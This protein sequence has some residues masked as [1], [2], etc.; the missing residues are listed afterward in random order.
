MK[1]KNFI[2]S[3]IIILILIISVVVYYFL[4]LPKQQPTER[5]QGQSIEQPINGK[6]NGSSCIDRYNNYYK[7]FDLTNHEEFS[8]N[9]Q[10]GE[11]DVGFKKDMSEQEIQNFTKSKGLKLKSFIDEINSA[12]VVVPDGEELEWVCKLTDN[13]EPKVVKEGTIIRYAE[14]VPLPAPDPLP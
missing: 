2:T 6:L 4:K 9:F 5:E 14:F 11:I 3:A 7:F 10:S 13:R 1:N 12:R 8:K